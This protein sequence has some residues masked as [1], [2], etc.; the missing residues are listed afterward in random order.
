MEE[1]TGIHAN[2]GSNRQIGKERKKTQAQAHTHRRAH[3][4]STRT[5]TS[6]ISTVNG[7]NDSIDKI[8]SQI[9]P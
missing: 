6:Q 7:K 4:Y 3:T 8:P 2:R 1:I 9:Q 5:R